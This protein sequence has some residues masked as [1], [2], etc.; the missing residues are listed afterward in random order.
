ML[1]FY[2]MESTLFKC[3]T[4]DDGHSSATATMVD[5]SVLDIDQALTEEFTL[6]NLTNDFVEKI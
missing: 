4:G 2:C 6:Q 5:N 3:S 1:Q